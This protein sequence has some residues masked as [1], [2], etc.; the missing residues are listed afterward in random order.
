[1]STNDVPDS[2]E[3][4]HPSGSNPQSKTD[5]ESSQQTKSLGEILQMAK[6]QGE[7]TRSESNSLDNFA[8]LAWQKS[9]SLRQKIKKGLNTTYSVATGFT[10]PQVRN[11]IKKYFNNRQPP[12][13]KK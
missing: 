10:N 5:T 6:K 12:S 9:T 4:K 11:E 3:L 13:A 1:M 8:K 2:Q 7:Q